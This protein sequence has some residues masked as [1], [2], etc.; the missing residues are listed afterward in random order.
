MKL[1]EM[2][3]KNFSFSHCVFKILVLQTYKPSAYFWVMVQITLNLMMLLQGA[4]TFSQSDCFN[5]FKSKDI[6][7]KL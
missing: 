4:R 5:S 1:L 3:R 7:F 6:C 2:S